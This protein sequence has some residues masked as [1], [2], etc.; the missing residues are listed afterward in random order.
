[1]IT[2]RRTDLLGQPVS[3]RDPEP[4]GEVDEHAQGRHLRRDE[5]HRPSRIGFGGRRLGAGAQRAAGRR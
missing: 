4:P 3:G 5:F 2:R 1:M